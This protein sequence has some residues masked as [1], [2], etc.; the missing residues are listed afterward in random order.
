MKKS[1]KRLAKE[2]AIKLAKLISKTKAGYQCEKCPK[3]KSQGWQMHGAHIL[4]VEWDATAAMPENILCLCATCHSMGRESQHEDPI[5]FARWF[6]AKWPGRYDEL[7]EI[8]T[9]Y[10]RNPFPKIDWELKCSE[11]KEIADGLEGYE[12]QST[13]N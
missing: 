8:A 2:R 3:N 5:P 9:S 4:P 7:R 13:P 6:E 12:S 1:K 11:L 10:V